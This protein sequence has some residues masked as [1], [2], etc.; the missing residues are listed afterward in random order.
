MEPFSVAKS[1]ND[2]KFRINSLKTALN[3]SKTVTFFVFFFLSILKINIFFKPRLVAISKTKPVSLIKEC[4]D[5][6]HRVF[7]ENYVQELFDK[8]KEVKFLKKELDF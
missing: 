2:I 8:S 1:L 7:G 3:L 6:D 4:Y 5:A